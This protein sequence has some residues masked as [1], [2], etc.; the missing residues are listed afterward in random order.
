MIASEPEQSSYTRKPDARFMLSHPTHLVAQGFGS[1][2]SPVV[3]GT[4][5]TLLGW[6]CFAVFTMRW[7][8]VFTSSTWMVLI[9][10]GFAIGIWCCSKTGRD[11]GV[12]DHGSMVWDEII[13]FWIVLLFIMPAGFLTQLSAFICFRIFDM[14]KPPP[15]GYVDRRIKGGFGVMLDDIVA[16]FY[17]LFV[18]A[19]WRLVW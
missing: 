19:I 6:L 13:A 8:D 2:L 9:V 14:A 4:F 5:G 11:L 7:P 17:T 16:A 12:S 18:F 15:V 1:G 10:V 3:P